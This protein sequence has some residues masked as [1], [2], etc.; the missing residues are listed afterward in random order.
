MYSD[1]HIVI[2]IV[3]YDGTFN[4]LLILN[5]THVQNVHVQCMLY[6]RNVVFTFIVFGSRFHNL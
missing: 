1:M 2:T 4:T 3:C 6:K 5:D